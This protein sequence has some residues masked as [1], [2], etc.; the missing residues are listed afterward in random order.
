MQT[1][2]QSI[3]L[4][5]CVSATIF[6]SG[7]KCT[8]NASRISLTPSYKTSTSTK[9]SVSP[10]LNS[11]SKMNHEKWVMSV[12]YEYSSVK[13]LHSHF[14]ALK[15]YLISDFL[16]I[17]CSNICCNVQFRIKILPSDIGL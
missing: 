2:R 5:T 4:F 7:F 11:I 1:T 10:S 16:K 3:W 9:C 8:V 14:V 6:S 12:K 17:L 13:V 15:T